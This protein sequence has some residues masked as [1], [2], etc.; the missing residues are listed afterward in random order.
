M[1]AREIDKGLHLIPLDQDR[2][3]F[4]E[5]ISAW[6][7]RAGGRTCLVDP[8]PRAT[9]PALEAAL[10]SLGVDRIDAILLT[11]I[12]LDHGGGVGTLIRSFPEAEVLCH[13]KA[14]KHLADPGRL[15]QGSL[16]V[17][18]SVA[19]MYGE[20]EPVPAERLRFEPTLE[21]GDLSIEVLETPGHA[22]NH[23]CFL[24]GETLFAGEVAGLFQPMDSGIYM[25]PATAPPFRHEITLASLDRVID[26]VTALGVERICFGHFGASDDAA[27]LLRLARDQLLLWIDAVRRAA[28]AEPG[29][30][31]EAALRTVHEEDEL[32]ASLDRLPGDIRERELYFVRNSIRGMV[33]SLGVKGSL[34]V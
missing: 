15:W 21:R 6:V 5:F 31:V 1:T 11:H 27:R 19:R 24:L 10:E 8:G 18:G 3:G 7:V 28:A 29:D 26:R 17:L 2:P 4:R 23:L 20:P 33:G 16:E 22:A 30:P 13:P 32:F 25:R 9:I 12:H 14:S 34:G